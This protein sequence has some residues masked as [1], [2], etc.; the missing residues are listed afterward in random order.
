MLVSEAHLAPERRSVGFV[1]Y[2]PQPRRSWSGLAVFAA[3]LILNETR[4]IY[5]VV[6]VVKA[7]AGQ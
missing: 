7:W 1:R 5:V 2:L 4:G 6:Q 3:L